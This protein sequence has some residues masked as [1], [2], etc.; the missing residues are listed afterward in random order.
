[1]KKR[2]AV[3]SLFVALAALLLATVPA[4]SPALTLNPYEQ[5]L[6]KVINQRRVKHHLARV[7][8]RTSLVVAARS[9]STE[10]DAQQYFAHNSPTTGECWS[11]RLIRCGYTRSGYSFWRAGENIFKI[12]GIYAAFPQTAVKAWMKSPAHRR[13]ILTRRFRDIGV[14]AVMSGDTKYVTLDLGRRIK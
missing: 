14:G 8:I 3:I 9:H 2:I 5:Q 7:H 6:V 4:A 1:M 10:M 13:V 12:S 11:A